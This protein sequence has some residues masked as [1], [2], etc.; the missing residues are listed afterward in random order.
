MEQET[1]NQYM[2]QAIEVAK[3]CKQDVPVGAII[4]KD[5]KVVGVGYNQKEKRQDATC[6]A[7]IMA[8]RQASKK[9]RNFY[10]DGC[11]MYVTFEPCLMCYGA[12]LSAR[13]DK[14]YY[15]AK[16]EKYPTISSGEQYPFNHKTQW[17]GG[18]LECECRQ[19]LQTFFQNLRREKQWSKQRQNP[20]Q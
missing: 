4:V 7:E 14:V 20:K 6:H 11:T 10:L 9:L 3:R 12:I 2:R 16:D 15:G 13:L 8:I 5:G 18:V 19:L 1:I 17:V